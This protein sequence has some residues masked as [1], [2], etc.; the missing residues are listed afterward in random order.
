MKLF[1]M[2]ISPYTAR[3]R[4]Q[5][6]AKGLED[7]I[8]IITPS[9]AD[10]KSPDYLAMNPM[11]K[12]PALITD[13]GFGLPESD[14]I[15][16]YIEDTFPTPGISAE[17]RAKVRL[18][19]RVG[20]TYVLGAMEPMFDVAKGGPAND[21]IL[22]RALELTHWG[23]DRLEEVLVGPYAA[24]DDLTYAD[25]TV[26]AILFYATT[27]GRMFGVEDPFPTRPKL[28]AYWQHIQKDETAARVLGEM[29]SALKALMGGK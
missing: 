27:T 11:G 14:V 21:A 8:E 28:A 24:G 29:Q 23:L 9:P 13:T 5:V 17:T 18:V 20:D 3:A 15:C 16:E 2:D 1:S 26:L 7:Q 19:S 10:L 4:L 6:Y 25:G 22:A 12:I